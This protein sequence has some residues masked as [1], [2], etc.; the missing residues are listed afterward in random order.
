MNSGNLHKRGWLYKMSMTV[1]KSLQGIEA[2]DTGRCPECG[3]KDLDKND[4]EI[5]CNKCG[6]VLD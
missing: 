6:F 3:S 1:P 5:S 2:E 4:T